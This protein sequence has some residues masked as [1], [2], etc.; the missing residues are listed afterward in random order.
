MLKMLRQISVLLLLCFI[1][2]PLCAEEY[3]E[4]DLGVQLGGSFYLG[5]INKMPFRGTRP[6]GGIFYRHNFNQRYS[7]KG[8]FSYAMLHADDSTFKH[9]DYQL[10]RGYSFTKN[11]FGFMALGEF[12]FVP[13]QSKGKMLTPYTLYLQG[14]LGLMML[15]V[16]DSKKLNVTVPFGLGVKYNTKKKWAYGADFLM[17]KTFSDKVD[18]VAD[19][20]SESNQI[21]QLSVKSGKD[22]FSYFAIYLSYKFEYPQKCPSF[23]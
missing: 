1:S 14:G 9:S 8:I 7:A 13:F 3:P 23:D 12:N 6:A 22:W 11:T 21:K 16:D 4:G 2:L 17:V 20:P 10:E 15:P 18:Y 5:D 19:C